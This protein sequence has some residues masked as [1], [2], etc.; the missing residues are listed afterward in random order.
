MARKTFA[1]FHVVPLF[2]FHEAVLTVT[3]TLVTS[4]MVYWNMLYIHYSIALEEYP[5]VSVGAEC[6]GL[7]SYLCP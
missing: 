1:Q 6:I 2:L 3:H 4:Q 5:G 7:G